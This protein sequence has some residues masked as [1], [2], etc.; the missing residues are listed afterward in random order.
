MEHDKAESGPGQGVVSVL[1]STHLRD[2]DSTVQEVV[3]R[4]GI[5]SAIVITSATTIVI[6]NDKYSFRARVTDIL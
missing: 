4:L 5:L 2:I 6:D 1:S 3:C